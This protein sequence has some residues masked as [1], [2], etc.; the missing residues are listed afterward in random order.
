MATQTRTNR[1]SLSRARIVDAAL[2]LAREMPLEDVSLHKVG[3]A[4][5]VSA[6][7]LYRYVA[8][9]ADLLDAMGDAVLAEIEIPVAN[10]DDWRSDLRALAVAFREVLQAHPNVAH[11][12]LTRRLNAPGTLP[13]FD[14]TLGILL[15]LGLPPAAAVDCVRAA[16]AFQIGT[17]V[18]EYTLEGNAGGRLAVDLDVDEYP[19]IAAAAPH[20]QVMD[21]THEF[22]QG[23]DL[24]I[25]GIEQ[26]L[27]GATART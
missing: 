7:S 25:A 26:R 11:I 1:G 2:E 24:L 19:N 3:E 27:R 20:L 22:E 10:G 13:V 16:V 12:V 4:L 18:R 15:R 6:M 14:A 8:S 5:G 17:H 23:L 21:H 9:K